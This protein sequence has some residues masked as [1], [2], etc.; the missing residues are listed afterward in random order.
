MRLIDNLKNRYQIYKLE[1][2]YARRGKR[3]TFTAAAQYVDGEYVYVS[4]STAKSSGATGYGS[5]SDGNNKRGSTMVE[6]WRRQS[7]A[8]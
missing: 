5:G 2:R 7:R 1:Q 8:F 3:S 4:S 6:V